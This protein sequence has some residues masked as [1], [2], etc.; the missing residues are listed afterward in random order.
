MRSFEKHRQ[1]Q[2]K[3]GYLYVTWLL[4]NGKLIKA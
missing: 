3:P 2:K 4:F 1:Q